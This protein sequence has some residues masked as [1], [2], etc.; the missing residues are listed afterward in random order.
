MRF[1]LEERS[2]NQGKTEASL[3]LV[4]MFIA[5]N[6]QLIIGSNN[7]DNLYDRIKAEYPDARISKHKG[8][9]T[10]EGK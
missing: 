9:V 7:V 6:K 5:A 2:R 10:I 8:Y 4:R 1:K 3:K